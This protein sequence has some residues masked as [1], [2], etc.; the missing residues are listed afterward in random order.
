LRAQSSHRSV[1]SFLYNFSSFTDTYTELTGGTSL[2]EGEVWD[3]PFYFMP[4]AFPFLI[5]GNEVGE[6]EFY[7]GGSLMRAPTEDPLV[8]NYIFPFEADLIDRGSFGN[9]SLS[10]ISYT[11]E[12]TPGN[13]IQKMQF[14]NAGSYTEMDFNGTLDMY[15]NFQMW[16]YEGTN[17]IE[18]H[19][20]PSFINDPDLFYDDY[21]GPLSG[22]ADY[23][24]DDDVITNAHFITGAAGNPSL[25]EDPTFVIGTPSDGMVYRLYLTPPLELDVIGENATSF[26]APNGT[27]TAQVSGGLEPYTYLWNNGATTPTISGLD[28]GTYSV[29][30]TDVNGQTETGSV[31]ITNVEP[32]DIVLITTDETAL[33][34]NDGTAEAQVTGGLL[35]YT[36]LWN[37][38]ETTS[39]IENLAPGVYNVVVTDASGCT[40]EQ[41]GVVNAFGC[42]ELLIEAAIQNASCNGV[43]DGSISIVDIINGSGDYTYDW[44]PTGSTLPTQLNLCAGLYDVTI[45]D[46]TGC[47]VIGNYEITE[48]DTLNIAVGFTNEYLLNQNDGTAWAIPSGGTPPYQYVWS[49]GGTD[50]LII[51]LSP[52]IYTVTVTDDHGC[53]ATGSATIE[54]G[55]CG[56][57]QSEVTTPGCFGECSGSIALSFINNSPP[58]TYSWD[59]GASTPV[60]TDLCAGNFTVTV[61]DNAGCEIVGTFTV[62]DPP[63]LIPGAGSTDE[64][65]SFNDGTAWVVPTGGAPPYTY[66][67]NN[68]S[69]DSLIVNLSP[70][71]YSVT[72][73]DSHGCEGNDSVEVEPYCSGHIVTGA[74]NLGCTDSCLW[75]VS[76]LGIIDIEEPVSYLWNTGDTVAFIDQL[77]PGLYILTVTEESTHC[78]YQDSFEILPNEPIIIEV[79]TVIHNTDTGPGSISVSLVN[80][81][82]PPYYFFWESDNGFISVDE[83]LTNLSGGYYTLQVRDSLGNCGQIDS[84]EVLDLVATTPVEE[85]KVDIFPNPAHDKVYIKGMDVTEY[86]IHLLDATGMEMKAWRNTNALEVADVLPGWY[87]L[88]ITSG[89]NS[90]IK[91][92][93]IQ[94]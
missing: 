20:G 17:T 72:V 22:T 10:P 14:K 83:D 65:E 11:V 45:T 77:C 5:N 29:T 69:T 56:I 41:T 67:W 30:V 91:P 28:A 60:I 75:T 58:I 87:I 44:S 24:E 21:P 82:T 54:A 81:T 2:N 53:S 63:A 93:L 13:R 64:T 89:K 9:T 1:Q 70:G 36:Y 80:G 84:I 31:T 76:F 47:L 6:L 86:E 25:S 78:M 42:P 12:G 16:L 94:R 40:A 23:N 3:D 49:N 33:A 43:C 34:A 74:I 57:I 92:L 51:N 38:G 88:K 37:N 90:L 18:F 7:G 8:Y 52:G 59:T 15:V 62:Q 79:D 55:P 26:C 32:L 73:V 46:V 85:W 66:Q 68:G 71:F 4:L 61:T 50:S 48:P 35:P 39:F 19:F 27:A